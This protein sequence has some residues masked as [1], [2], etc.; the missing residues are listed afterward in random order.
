MDLGP[1]ANFIWLCYG[2][3]AAIIGLLVLRLWLE[4]LRHA[5]ELARLEA[6]DVSRDHSS[7]I[8]PGKQ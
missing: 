3:V 5:R 6:G 4:G 8:R 2:A 7:R 1:H